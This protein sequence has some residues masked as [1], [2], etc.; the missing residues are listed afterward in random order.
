[1]LKTKPVLKKGSGTI[2]GPTPNSRLIA[3]KA[4][5]FLGEFSFLSI[6]PNPIYCSKIINWVI[7]SKI[8][9]KQELEVLLLD[10][11]HKTVG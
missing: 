5:L 9:I 4:A 7:K 1:M 3:V 10:S 8:I 6:S 11:H 2:S